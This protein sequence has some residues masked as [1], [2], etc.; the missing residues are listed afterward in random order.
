MFTRVLRFAAL[1]LVV[2]IPSLAGVAAAAGP[3]IGATSGTEPVVENQ[4][5]GAAFETTAQS[6]GDVQVLLSGVVVDSSGTPVT[7]ARVT[8][9][10]PDS[11]A[12][13]TDDSGRFDVW[14]SGSGAGTLTLVVEKQ[15]GS[16][17]LHAVRTVT[18][19]ASEQ[20]HDLGLVTLGSTCEPGWTMGLF[21]GPPGFNDD[22]Y[23]LTVYD[24][25]GSGPNPPQLVAG[26]FFTTAG[27][28][29]ANRIARWNPVTS[30]WSSFGT[31]TANGVNFMVRALTVYDDDGAGPNRPQLV[32]GGDFT[33]AGGQAANFIARWNP[34]TNSWS[35][36]GT[37]TTNGVNDF[38]YALTVYDDDGS[39]PNRPQLVAGGSFTA[40]GGQ[41]ANY[42]ARWN[43]LT[44]SWSSFGT[45][46]A[47]G[48]SGQVRALTVYDDDGAGPNPPQLVAGGFFTTAGGQAANYIARWNPL[49][50][51]WSSFVTGSANGVDST[52]Y[53]LTVYDDDGSGP[54]GPQLVAG[55]FF[56]TAGGQTA[57]RIARWNPVTSSWSSVG[58]GTAN[59][60][61]N[62][63]R[64]LT[65]YDDDGTGPNPPQLAAGG[66][67][68]IAGGQTAN[69]IARWNPLTSSWSSFGM[70]TANGVNA[71]V[72][73][74]TVY[75]DGAVGPALY[76]GGSFITA[77][78]QPSWYVARWTGCPVAPTPC[79]GDA[80][81]SGR[82]NFDDM[83]TVLANFGNM[84]TAYG[85]GDADGSGQV[86]FDDVTT[87]L[88]NFGVICP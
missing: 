55:G 58:T 62:T 19:S 88:G 69:S 63:V 33:T 73:A 66:F 17:A 79:P 24:D 53:A 34:A 7:G 25:D 78:G 41:T 77:G 20:H 35:S 13:L 54:N 42:I 48:V 37:G 72:Y 10:E 70:G 5:V 39:G 65:V 8:I 64:A 28:Q 14:G 85:P 47:N 22:V 26:G 68:T 3:D 52:I 71:V 80:D 67:F 46:T 2:A 82:V 23:A 15:L 57:N 56:T 43:P 12:A 76:A 4:A 36:F 44:S 81:G 18:V 60:V 75:D 50:N 9:L 32:A 40:A 49:N 74:L 21:P 86:N 61:N 1:L 31:G 83:T 16:E 87:V 84:T 59:G 29:V 27:G 51:S 45:G 6:V 30:S 11:A 38:V